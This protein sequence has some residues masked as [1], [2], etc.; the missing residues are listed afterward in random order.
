MSYKEIW[1]IIKAIATYKIVFNNHKAKGSFYEQMNLELLSAEFAFWMI[2]LLFAVNVINVMRPMPIGW[3][4]LGVYMNFPKLFATNNGLFHG[5]GLVVWQ[6]FTGIG[7]LFKSAT[8]AFF[9][10]QIGGVLSVV[11]IAVSLTHFTKKENSP[12][13]IHIPMLLAA[14]FY[15][16][17]MV[18]FQQA[19]DMKLDPNLMAFSIMAVFGLYV[20]CA[21]YWNLNV[22]ERKEYFKNS[23]VL[24]ILFA[25]GF[26]AGFCFIVKLT[27]IMLI[28]G[29]FAVLLYVQLGIWGFL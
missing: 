22:E 23:T 18:I 29:F 20:V 25:I 17:P 3:D 6:L 5:S 19:K 10:N 15:A 11:A 16:M 12:R 4:D 7:F 14:A 26:L 27:S 24:W 8:Q 2:T 9:I 21:E 13:F 1:A 28:L